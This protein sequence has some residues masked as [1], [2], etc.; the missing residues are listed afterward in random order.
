MGDQYELR[1]VAQVPYEFD[2][3]LCVRLVQR[4]V[5]LVY[6]V[7]RARLNAEH[8]EQKGCRRQHLLPYGEK[9]YVLHILAGG[10]DHNVNPRIKQVVRI[11]EYQRGLTSS[12]Y[13]FAGLLE[14]PVH[15]V[16]CLA[17]SLGGGSVDL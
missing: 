9:G 2:E 14:V 5:H 15:Y 17:E 4:G 13:A 16:K 11:G 7:E 1:G 8:S 10:L 6:E 12:E 3:A